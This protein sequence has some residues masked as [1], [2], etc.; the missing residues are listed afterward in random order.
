MVAS[1]RAGSWFF[2]LASFSH[3]EF[4]KAPRNVQ[5]QSVFAEVSLCHFGATLMRFGHAAGGYQ[6]EKDRAG[7]THTF[8][9]GLSF[10]SVKM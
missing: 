9:H 10:R 8:D 1:R 4:N 7:A 3:C 2:S 6:P 5:L